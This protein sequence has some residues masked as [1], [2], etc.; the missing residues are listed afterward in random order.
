VCREPP[1]EE[2]RDYS[3]AEHDAERGAR[4]VGSRRH[5][6]EPSMDGLELSF[7]DGEIGAGLVG[8]AQRKAGRGVIGHAAMFA[9][10]G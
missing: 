7:D 6:G 3:G 2:G 8:L 10:C 4:Q 9:E 5:P 1:Y